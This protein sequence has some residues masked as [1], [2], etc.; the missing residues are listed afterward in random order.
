MFGGIPKSFYTA[1]HEHYPKTEP[2]AEYDLRADLY[3]LFHYLNH[4][5]LFGVKHFSSYT[6]H[7]LTL[8]AGI[9]CW[10]KLGKD[11]WFASGISR[12][13][14]NKFC[15]KHFQTRDALSDHKF[16]QSHF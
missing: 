10:R 2:V 14:K 8:V 11:G 6:D 4:T 7:S 15:N 5:V 13:I 3:E 1:Y 16:S 12:R 9:L